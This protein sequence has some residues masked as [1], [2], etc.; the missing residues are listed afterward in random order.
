[1]IQVIHGG[2]SM[3]GQPMEY[4]ASAIALLATCVGVIGGD[5]KSKTR[6]LWQLTPIGWLA[7]SLAVSAFGVSVVQTYS[8]RSA[9]ASRR[10]DAG[11]I[12]LD[13]AGQ[14]SLA[15]YSSSSEHSMW[16]LKEVVAQTE[17]RL[18]EVGARLDRILGLYGDAIPEAAKET[19]VQLAQNLSENAYSLG[20]R[21]L[22]R[23]Y[24][25]ALDGQLRHLTMSI[26]GS[27]MREVIQ[28]PLLDF[29][30]DF[31][32]PGVLDSGIP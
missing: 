7:L 11:K 16:P 20:D 12:L 6:K 9:D 25:R 23:D 22:S 8:I 13:A 17:K 10:A 28:S 4:I 29:G 3:E 19:A 5:H 27:R 14:V 30:L 32:H 15:I 1:M 18:K 2:S 26:D 24:L 31:D 21:D